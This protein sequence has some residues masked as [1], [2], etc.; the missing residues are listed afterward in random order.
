MTLYGIPNCNT[1]KKARDWLQANHIAYD[2]YDFKKNGIN[3]ATLEHWLSQVPHEK[4]V[5]RA[6]MTW[7]GL[8]DEDKANVTNNASAIVL[9]LEKTSIIKRPVLVK[10]GQIISLGFD[11]A[12]YR[13]LL[14]QW[15]K[16]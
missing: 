15:V 13:K 5:N 11:E 4:L 8:S 7:R 2:F 10:N 14:T 3:A 9:M 12:Q 16:L 6:G 1:I